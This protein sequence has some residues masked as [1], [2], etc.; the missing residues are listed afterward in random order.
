MV[1]A[2]AQIGAA[3]AALFPTLS[4]TGSLGA[5]SA[6]LSNLLSSGAGVWSLGLS[7]LAPIFAGGRR[8]ARVEQ[9]EARRAQAL[10]GYQ[11]AIETAFREV[12]DALASVEQSAGAEA[13]LAAR[14][15]AARN[16]LELSNERYR[17]GYSP[18]L[19]VLDAQRTANEAELAFVRN[20][21]ARLAF[22]VDLMRA[23][24][25]GWRDPLPD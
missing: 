6:E 24:G 20:R 2:N 8:E 16:A 7:A 25:G 22:S 11:R 9:A 23:L 17:A 10:A 18:F 1:A 12:A 15:E 5:Q 19:E 13:D 14:L 3:R 4:L 21:Q